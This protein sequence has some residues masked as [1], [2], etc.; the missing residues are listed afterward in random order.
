MA[1]YEV[2]A[3]GITV[4]EAPVAPFD[5]TTVPVHPDAVSITDSPEQITCLLALITGAVGVATFTVTK[6]E[7]P[8]KQTPFLQ[9]AV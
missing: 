7:L 6:L 9:V 2:D 8:L 1:V 3:I 4:I 5:H